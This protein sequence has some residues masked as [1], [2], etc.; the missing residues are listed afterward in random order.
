VPD[1]VKYPDLEA[2][3]VVQAVVGAVGHCCVVCANATTGRGAVTASRAFLISPPFLLS[4]ARR[5]SP[6]RWSMPPVPSPSWT[7]RSPVI[8][9][10]PARRRAPPGRGGRPGDRS[11]TG[12]RALRPATP[13]QPDAWVPAFLRVEADDARQ[14]LL[15]MRRAWRAARHAVAGRRHS[16]AAAVDL[17]RRGSTALGLLARRRPR[18]GREERRAAARRL[19]RCRHRH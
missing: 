14:L 4:S 7:R 13:W 5:H 12:D 17:P 19:L 11:L 1:V 2:G 8:R 3:A 10:C 15:E 16:H 6:A 18:H 9:C